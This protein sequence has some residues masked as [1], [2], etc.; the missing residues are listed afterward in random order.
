[1]SIA[2]C[3]TTISATDKFLPNQVNDGIVMEFN[4]KKKWRKMRQC[5]TQPKTHLQCFYHVYVLISV[6]VPAGVLF[7]PHDVREWNVPASKRA[8]D[9]CDALRSRRADQI[10]GNLYAIRLVSA[11]FSFCRH[12]FSVQCHPVNQ[13]G[14]CEW[15]IGLRNKLLLGVLMTGITLLTHRTRSCQRNW[16]KM[17]H[18]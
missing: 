12:P 8:R 16:G 3:L 5:I 11:S 6:H 18:F 1:M 10:V 9:D 15:E 13:S 14:F 2:L 17:S 4:W 7:C